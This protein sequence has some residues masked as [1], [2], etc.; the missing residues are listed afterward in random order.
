MITHSSYIKCTGSR[1][2]RVLFAEAFMELFQSLHM[3]EKF[4]A[5]ATVSE[6][7]HGLEITKK[8]DIRNNN[9]NS[10]VT[11]GPPKIRLTK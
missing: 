1:E 6:L 2:A 3:M 7:I 11:D 9:G 8:K 10:T 4:R 5:C